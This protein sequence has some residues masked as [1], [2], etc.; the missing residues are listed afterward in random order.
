MLRMHP[1]ISNQSEF[2]QFIYKSVRIKIYGEKNDLAD[3][4]VLYSFRQ[5]SL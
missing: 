5:N 1:L 2:I 4:K 3:A